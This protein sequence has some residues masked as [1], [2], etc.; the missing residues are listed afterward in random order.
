MP[1]QNDPDGAALG[2][3]LEIGGIDIGSW[4]PSPE[5]DPDP[6]PPTQVHMT[7][8]LVG[9]PFPIIA[10]FKSP[11]T[12]GLVADALAEHRADVWPDAR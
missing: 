7:L 4:S 11:R 5:G 8:H 1:D 9:L 2:L 6:K 12:L 3:S 10:R